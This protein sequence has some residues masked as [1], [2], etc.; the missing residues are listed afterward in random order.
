MQILLQLVP[1][2]SLCRPLLALSMCGGLRE[3]TKC[4]KLWGQQAWAQI[5]TSF[6]NFTSLSLD[7][8][9]YKMGV[10]LLISELWLVQLKVLTY[11][12]GL[13]MEH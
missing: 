2:G 12:K 7:F 5:L 13:G 3:V 1:A 11:F 4:K 8:S 6:T 10:I 9:I